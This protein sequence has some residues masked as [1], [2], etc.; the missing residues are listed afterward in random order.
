META[1]TRRAMFMGL[2]PS[3]I[4]SDNLENGQQITHIIKAKNFE[5][6]VIVKTDKN[7]VM[8]SQQVSWY[9]PIS[10]ED[11]FKNDNQLF[12]IYGDEL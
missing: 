7:Y 4:A 1:I 8:T 6:R 9:D 3:K 10:K 5:M 11:M 2:I 12:L